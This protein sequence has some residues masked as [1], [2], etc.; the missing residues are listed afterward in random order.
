MQSHAILA[1]HVELTL[2]ARKL[3]PHCQWHAV[4]PTVRCCGCTR[5]KDHD[6]R[7]KVPPMMVPFRGSVSRKLVERVRLTH[8]LD[9]VRCTWGQGYRAMLAEVSA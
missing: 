6:F 4:S 3:N 2:V 7:L 5:R 9:E 1:D 8:G